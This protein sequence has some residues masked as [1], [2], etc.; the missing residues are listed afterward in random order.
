MQ[1]EVPFD[2]HRHPGVLPLFCFNGCVGTK[3]H[4]AFLFPSSMGHVLCL[5]PHLLPSLLRSWKRGRVPWPTR[6]PRRLLPCGAA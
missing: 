5:R 6:G 4:M 1:R 2:T 3:G